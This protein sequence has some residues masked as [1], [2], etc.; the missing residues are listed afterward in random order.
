MLAIGYVVLDIEG[1]EGEIDLHELK[2]IPHTMR[3]RL[4]Y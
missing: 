4:L 2:N 1:I 3:V